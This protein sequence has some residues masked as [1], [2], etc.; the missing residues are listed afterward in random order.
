MGAGVISAYCC[1]LLV[2]VF[3]ELVLERAGIFR[4][5]IIE[6]F[7]FLY[8]REV[9]TAHTSIFLGTLW[10]LQR[11]KMSDMFHYI[12]A[13]TNAASLVI[14]SVYLGATLTLFKG[15]QHPNFGLVA[16]AVIMLLP[17]CFKHELI[18]NP[19]TIRKDSLVLLGNA[20]QRL[21]INA[22]ELGMFIVGSPGCGKTKFL[23]EPLLYKLI[24]RGDSGILYDYDFSIGVSAKNYSL[25]QLA[26][27]CVARQGKTQFISVNF[28]DVRCSARINPIAPDQIVDRKKLS[29]TLRTLLLNLNP[30]Q[31]EDFWF[32]NTYSL[33]KGIVVLMANAFPKYCT[34]P[35]VIMLSLQPQ[36]SLFKLLQID[37]EAELYARPVLDAFDKA[38][39]QLTG[40]MASFQVSL[41][42]LL[43]HNL[44]W[45]LS[46][47]EVPHQINDVQHPILLCLGNTPTQKEVLSPVLSMITAA[48]ISQM[49]AHERNRSFLMIDELPTILLP[50]LS[51]VPAT[52]RKYGI[53]T[54]VA[55][56]NFAQ[57][58]K[59]YG[60]VGAMELQETFSN[61]FVGRSY[62][63][64]STEVSKLF[65]K[66]EMEASSH[67]ISEDRVSKTVHERDKMVL[68]PQ[69]ILN[70][71]IGEFVGK[72]ADR[73]QGFFK[74]KLQ[75]ISTY[76]R[77][78]DYRRFKELPKVRSSVDAAENFKRI[79]QEV[80][81]ILANHT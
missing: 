44:F 20:G 37:Q 15:Y 6:I 16:V 27:N 39:E 40:V 70:L 64:L 46:G 1:I 47:D 34:L 43:D 62:L 63:Q 5:P 32:K 36:A 35:H 71:G 48:W 17:L 57:L 13:R 80:E 77:E 7:A 14:V 51:E 18:R 73:G 55:L 54:I 81:A 26:Y 10:V 79:Q 11:G 65:G 56:Q 12:W 53:A 21:P 30:N 61:H 33:L 50:N 29:S 59:R 72:L 28:Q 67:T 38:P 8:R 3:H 68:S 45:V 24:K 23:V 25:S 75:P 2:G 78:L 31:K 41:E 42:R 52:A 66:Q 19:T 9:W 49:Y 58:E 4:M 74:M 69:E 22:P 76:G 60:K